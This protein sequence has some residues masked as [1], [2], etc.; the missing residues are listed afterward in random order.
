MRLGSRRAFL[1][2]LAVCIAM[3]SDNPTEQISQSG[4]RSS[5]IQLIAKS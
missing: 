1:A 2:A 4:G 5:T 3:C